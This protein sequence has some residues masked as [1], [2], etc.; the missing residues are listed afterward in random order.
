MNYDQLI[1]SIV[2][3]FSK[4]SYKKK[5]KKYP[6]GHYERFICKHSSDKCEYKRLIEIENEINFKTWRYKLKQNPLL[7][8]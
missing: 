2:I 6:D 3:A 7:Q 5:Y 8:N 1:D 4:C